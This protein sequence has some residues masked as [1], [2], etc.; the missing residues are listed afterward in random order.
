LYDLWVVVVVLVV[1]F[2][3]GV[4]YVVVELGVVVFVVI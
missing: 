1:E 3:V 4:Y 2:V